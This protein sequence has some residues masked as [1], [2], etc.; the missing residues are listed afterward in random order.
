MTKLLFFTA[1]KS[2]RRQLSKCLKRFECCT[3]KTIDVT[4]YT[5]PAILITNNS[6]KITYEINNLRS[7]LVKTVTSLRRNGHQVVVLVKYKK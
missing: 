2:S 4:I 3:Y 6:D 7:I 1:T 5:K